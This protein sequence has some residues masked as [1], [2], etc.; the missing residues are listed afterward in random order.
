READG[1]MA[2]FVLGPNGNSIAVREQVAPS[3]GWGDWNGSF[4]TASATVN[5]SHNADGRME[6]FALAPGGANISHIWQTAPN[7]G[8]SAW[9]GDGTFGSAAWTGP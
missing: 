4:G 9:N 6:V 1:R 8:W 7:G 2:V 5:V 3:A